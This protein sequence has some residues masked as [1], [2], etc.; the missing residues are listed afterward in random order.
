MPGGCPL[1]NTAV[2]SDEGNIQL[3]GKA[4]QALHSWLD[5]LQSIAAEGQRQGEVR[6]DVDSAELATLIASILEG[7]SRKSVIG[8]WL[9]G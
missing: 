9:C 7:I 5:R 6:L 8:S 1:L 4:R 3:R 2:D